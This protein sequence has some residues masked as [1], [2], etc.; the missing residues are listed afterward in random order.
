MI[1]LLLSNIVMYSITSK[2]SK[3]EHNSGVLALQ[4]NNQKVNLKL[5]KYFYVLIEAFRV[6]RRMH[7]LVTCD[8]FFVIA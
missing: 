3:L 5:E 6:M 1:S 2:I 8:D 7:I 4:T